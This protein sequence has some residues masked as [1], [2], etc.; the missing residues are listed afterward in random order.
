MFESHSTES[1]Q[2]LQEK[3]FM[4]FLAENNYSW[5]ELEEAYHRLCGI[6]EE[7]IENTRVENLLEHMENLST[8]HF[9]INRFAHIINS[10]KD[11][12]DSVSIFEH[13][14]RDLAVSENEK[15]VLYSIVREG[16]AGKL[17]GHVND[18][19]VMELQ[20]ENEGSRED[21]AAIL[22]EALR[23]FV[24]QTRNRQRA[25]NEKQ[26]MSFWFEAD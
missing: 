2:V 19:V 23:K 15:K 18:D 7:K 21:T 1:D 4:K 16:R 9:P 20:V 8:Q 12:E 10:M 5:A 11:L 24:S 14:V 22:L 17:E 13:F 25:L 3:E 6:S 26:S